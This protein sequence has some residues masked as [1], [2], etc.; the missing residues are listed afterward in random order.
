MARSSGHILPSDDVRG[1]HFRDPAFKKSMVV[2]VAIHLLIL[3]LAGTVTL[4]RLPGTSYS[5]TYTVDLVTLPPSPAAKKPAK[6][7]VKENIP[8]S[9]EKKTT[10]VE[11]R[12]DKTQ[13]KVDYSL[14][15]REAGDEDPVRTG[16]KKRLKE[17]EKEAEK[18]FKSYSLDST[19]RSASSSEA[20][21]KV[22]DASAAAG[23]SQFSGPSVVGGGSQSADIRFR[24]YYDQV[25]ARI[26]AA[27]VLP[28]GVAAADG[29][30]LTV[31]GIRISASGVIEDQR[32]ERSSGNIYYDQS[33]VRALNK[34]SPLPPLPAELSEDILEVG[35]NFRVTE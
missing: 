9:V 19:Q 34:A 1:H 21:R 30:L 13:R 23:V 32:I 12:P 10:V 8:P 14:T 22:S 18:L 28:D 6:S 35:I 31:I 26:K 15:R 33:A 24:A 5:P 17:M 29:K 4:F 20:S 16:R 2:S 11:S 3:V 7:S 25:W 27:W